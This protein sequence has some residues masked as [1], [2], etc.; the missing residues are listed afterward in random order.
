[1]TINESKYPFIFKKWQFPLKVCYAM[2]I[3]TSQGQLLN[4][5]GLY[6]EDEFSVM[7]NYMLHYLE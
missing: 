2:T 5:I 1:M 7:D 4:K 6:L 3:N